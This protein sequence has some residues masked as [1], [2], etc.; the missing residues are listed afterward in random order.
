[1]L[2]VCHPGDLVQLKWPLRMTVCRCIGTD[3]VS[4]V[5]FDPDGTFLIVN[6]RSSVLNVLITDGEKLGWISHFDL[7][8]VNRYNAI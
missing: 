4:T 5:Y 1:M 6:V 8:S 2:T 7:T 3:D